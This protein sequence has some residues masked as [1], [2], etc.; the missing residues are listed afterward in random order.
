MLSIVAEQE[1]GLQEE[2]EAWI[3]YE[4]TLV[5]PLK[6]VVSLP[7]AINGTNGGYSVS[8]SYAALTQEQ[9]T[10]LSEGLLPLLLARKAE[11][12]AVDGKNSVRCVVNART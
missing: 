11:L 12:A 3:Y 9:K 4:S 2:R 10:Y 6:D 8:T 5:A 1:K 7:D